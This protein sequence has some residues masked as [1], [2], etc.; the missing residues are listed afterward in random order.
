VSFNA[1]HY[2]GGFS[3]TATNENNVTVSCLW[4]D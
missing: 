2:M 4:E 3:T 1:R